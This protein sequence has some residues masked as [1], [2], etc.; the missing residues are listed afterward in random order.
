MI[1]TSTAQNILSIGIVVCVLIAL[2]I[3]MFRGVRSKWVTIGERTGKGFNHHACPGLMDIAFRQAN[4]IDLVTKIC[5]MEFVEETQQAMAI[6]EE[7]ITKLK[8]MYWSHYLILLKN[9]YQT[10]TGI[11]YDA[12]GRDYR[13]IIADGLLMLKDNIRDRVQENG[14]CDKSDLDWDSY[15]T[16]A[17]EHFIYLFNSYIDDHYYNDGKVELTSLYDHNKQ[18]FP[19]TEKYFHDLFKALRAKSI[20]YRD[21]V[22]ILK[23][24]LNKHL[25]PPK[26]E[27]EIA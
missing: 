5:R 26:G 16:R 23:Q 3:I 13:N 19:Q 12:E 22:N 11:I 7:Y 17:V 15:T 4:I 10:K 21:K 25:I 14:F 6:V 8:G 24:E 20:E 27:N 18:I 2:I 9:E 1:I